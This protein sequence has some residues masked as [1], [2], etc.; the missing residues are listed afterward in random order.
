MREKFLV[1][2]LVCIKCSIS[3]LLLLLLMCVDQLSYGIM[4]SLKLFKIPSKIN[5]LLNSQTFP[6]TWDERKLYSSFF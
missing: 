1:Y 3:I 2:C 5:I 4:A 6:V